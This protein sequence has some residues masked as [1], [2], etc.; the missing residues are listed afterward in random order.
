[1]N[2]NDLISAVA[3]GAG[4]TK[5]DGAK[6]VEAF[7]DAIQTT[8]QKKEEV[9]LVGFGTFSVSHRPASTG[10]HP[11][12]RE[13]MQIRESWQAKFKPGKVLK[14]ALNPPSE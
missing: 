1:M 11:R 10:R 3:E 7:L 12:T 13:P 2:K 9:R 6:A 8:L 14:D 4:L 5:A